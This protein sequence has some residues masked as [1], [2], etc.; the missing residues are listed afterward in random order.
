[1]MT[2]RYSSR[3]T[4]SFFFHLTFISQG[5]SSSRTTPDE[6]HETHFLLDFLP[7]K[8]CQKDFFLGE[9][10]DGSMVIEEDAVVV[11]PVA[12]DDDVID[13]GELTCS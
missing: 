6:F 7:V 4:C 9:D 3:Q 2:L 5:R 12:D 8:S 13:V 11:A 1:M 10:F